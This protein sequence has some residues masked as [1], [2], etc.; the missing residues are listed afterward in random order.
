MRLHFGLH[1]FGQ[2]ATFAYLTLTMQQAPQFHAAA[3]PQ[4][5]IYNLVVANLWPLYWVAHFIDPLR[6]NGAYWRVFEVS[7]ARAADLHHI[8]QYLAG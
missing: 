6:L 2:V 1:F 7:A 3:W 5:S 4:F 8:V